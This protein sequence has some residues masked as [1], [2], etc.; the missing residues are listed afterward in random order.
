MNTNHSLRLYQQKAENDIRIALRKG[1]KAPLLVLPTGSGKTHIFTSIASKAAQRGNR[2]LIIVHRSFLWEQVSSKLTDIGVEHGIIAPGRTSTA[3][4]IQIASVDTLIRRLDKTT[5]PDII[6]YD[7]AHHVVAG[8]KWGRVAEYWPD[9]PIIGVTATPVRTSGQGLGV[10]SNGYF[11]H[12]IIGAQISDLS[13]EYIAPCKLFAPT[14]IDLS[15]V[16]RVAGDYDRKEVGKRVDTKKI[17]GSV[18]GHYKLIC[19]GVPAIAFC[20]SIKHAEHVSEEFQSAGISSAS[21][22]GKT[23]KNRREYLFDALARGKIM[24]LTSCDLVSEGFD[25]PICGCAICLRPT[26]SLGLCLQ[27]WGRPAR[28]YPGKKWAYILDHVGNYTRH[29]MPNAYREWSLEGAKHN[30]TTSNEEGVVAVRT[31]PVCFNVH[32][33]A[34]VCPECSHVYANMGRLPE[35]DE[36]IRLREIEM[37]KVKENLKKQDIKFQRG[38]CRSLEELEEFARIHNYKSGWARHVWQS[39]QKKVS[40]YAV[41]NY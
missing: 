26:Q 7:E 3:D 37:E 16:K 34:P 31:C 32:A 17:Y 22:S 1:C 20:V 40:K 35:T 27:Q 28:P 33:P 39:R 38:G 15:G 21:V 2:T 8:N 36:R 5:K 6:I 12:L 23:P 41:C 30:P 29:G 9:V 13:P 18:P 24:V 25:V 4:K 10:G 14:D 19:Y 11:D